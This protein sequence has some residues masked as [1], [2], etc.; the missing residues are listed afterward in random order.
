MRKSAMVSPLESL[1][2]PT[3]QVTNQFWLGLSR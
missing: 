1:T 3:A 2:Y